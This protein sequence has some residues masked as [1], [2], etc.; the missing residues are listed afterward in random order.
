M[1]VCGCGCGYVY[2]S[3]YVCMH[4]LEEGLADD[5]IEVCMYVYVYVYVYVYTPR[6]RRQQYLYLSLSI[7]K[8]ALFTW[9][10]SPFHMAKEPCLYGKRDTHL[11]H[12]VVKTLIFY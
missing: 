11:D 3:L 7:G 12:V 5:V 6:S 10:K 4:A 1:C 8:R 9:Q 2:L